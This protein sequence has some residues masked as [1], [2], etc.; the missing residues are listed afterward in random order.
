MKKIFRIE[1]ISD[2]IQTVSLFE[3]FDNEKFLL[4][5]R[6]LLQDKEDGAKPITIETER[7]DKLKNCFLDDTIV[8]NG[9]DIFLSEWFTFGQ[10]SCDLVN[11]PH[12]IDMVEYIEF[13][14]MPRKAVTFTFNIPILL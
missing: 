13:K 6:M 4:R 7:G 3:L 10:V 11:L 14:L 9:V 2:G 5:D 1:N 12:K 8:L